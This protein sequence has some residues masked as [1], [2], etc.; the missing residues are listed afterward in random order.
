MIIRRMIISTAPTVDSAAEALNLF[1]HEAI[2]I[3]IPKRRVRQSQRRK[4][5]WLTDDVISATRI[6]DSVWRKIVFAEK[7]GTLDIRDLHRY[8][9]LAKK[10]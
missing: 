3:Y 10:G 4:P 8:Y 9:K 7:H 6:R 1:I 2:G 5:K